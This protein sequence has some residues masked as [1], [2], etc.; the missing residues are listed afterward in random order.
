[1]FNICETHFTSQILMKNQE[2][3]IL[4]HGYKSTRGSDGE[5]CKLEPD[6]TQPDPRGE[7]VWTQEALRTRTSSIRLAVGGNRPEEFTELDEEPSGCAP[8]WKPEL[9]GN[10]LVCVLLLTEL[11]RSYLW[12]KAA[13]ITNFT[14]LSACRAENDLQMFSEMVKKK[15][16]AEQ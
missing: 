3:W 5:A 12:V 2:I 4:I 13:G 14:A 7:R 6:E 11:S 15:F 10:T 8:T 16:K 9:G 1:M